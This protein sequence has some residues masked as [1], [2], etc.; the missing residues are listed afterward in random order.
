MFLN[1]DSAFV[2]KAAT[3]TTA[4]VA[5]VIVPNSAPPN[6]VVPVVAVA[7]VTA[8]DDNFLVIAFAIAMP[9]LP[10]F[11]TVDEEVFFPVCPTSF[12]YLIYS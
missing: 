2:V 8:T 12:F 11:C 3:V 7:V 10:L 9:V 1:P 4:H 6:V 5:P